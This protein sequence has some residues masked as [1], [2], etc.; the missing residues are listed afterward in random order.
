MIRLIELDI[1]MLPPSPNQLRSAHWAKL[2]RIR[3]DAS[4]AVLK[5]WNTAG[6]PGAPKTAAVV[7]VVICA[8]GRAG[9]PDNAWARMKPIL[10]SL[11]EHLLLVD[12]SPAWLSLGTISH[13]KAPPKQGHVL[14]TITYQEAS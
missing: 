12:D 3:E 4:W 7:D 8:H 9:D 13:A 1:P 11:V 10:D 6:R 14:V 2:H 5:A